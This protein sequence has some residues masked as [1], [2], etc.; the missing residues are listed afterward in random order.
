MYFLASK[1]KTL[2]SK[3]TINNKGDFFLFNK[4][5]KD[6]YLEYANNSDKSTRKR[7]K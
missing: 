6:F 4:N 7:K 3:T 1:F 5:N 2:Y